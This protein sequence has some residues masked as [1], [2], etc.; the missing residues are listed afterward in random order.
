MKEVNDLRGVGSFQEPCPLSILA[1]IVLSKASVSV[2]TPL[3][4]EAVT[5]LAN[6]EALQLLARREYVQ[7]L[8]EPGVADALQVSV[9]ILKI[10]SK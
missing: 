3:V 6:K 1:Y 2:T 4:L 5:S 7:M 9:V 10:N 8:S